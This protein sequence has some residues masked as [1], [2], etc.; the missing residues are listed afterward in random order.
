MV[1]VR[2]YIYSLKNKEGDWDDEFE[3]NGFCS[4]PGPVP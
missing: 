4:V 2:E 3:T 1:C